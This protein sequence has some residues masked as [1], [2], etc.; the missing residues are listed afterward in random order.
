MAG[1]GTCVKSAEGGKGPHAKAK[2]ARR[3]DDGLCRHTVA[4][5]AEPLATFRKRSVAAMVGEDHR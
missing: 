4:A 1:S 5:D 3:A 2:R